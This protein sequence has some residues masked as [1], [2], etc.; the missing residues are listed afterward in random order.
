MRHYSGKRRVVD[1]GDTGGQSERSSDANKLTLCSPIRP[2]QH[3]SLVMHL[4]YEEE[5]QEFCL[6]D[7][8]E[9]YRYRP[10]S[11]QESLGCV[12][13]RFHDEWQEPAYQVYSGLLSGVPLA[14]TS[15]AESWCQ[16]QALIKFSKRSGQWAVNQ[17]CTL[18]GSPFAA[19]S[20]CRAQ[21]LS[22]A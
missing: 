21:E 15:C 8:W 7:A 4:W 16:S 6:H 22:W 2:A 5:I 9:T 3:V 14:I 11:L 1:N 19:D 13:V 18:I 17:L 20:I 10:M 12:V